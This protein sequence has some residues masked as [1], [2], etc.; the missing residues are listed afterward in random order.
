MTA[1]LN[2]ILFAKQSQ[3]QFAVACAGFLLGLFLLLFAADLYLKLTRLLNPDAAVADYFLISQDI[4]LGNTIFGGRSKL[5]DAAV[6]DLSQQSFIKDVGVFTSNQF[7]VAAYAGGNLGFSTELFFEA[8]PDRFIDNCPPSFVWREDS[9]ELPVVLSQEMLNLYNFGYALS[10]GLP[11]LS[12]SA[13]ALVP[14]QVQISGKGGVR[15]FRGK[16]VGFSERIPSVIVPENFMRWANRTIGENQPESGAARVVAR[17]SNP[18]SPEL[19]AYMKREGLVL[20]QDKLNASKAGGAVQTVMSFVGVL[21]IFLTLSSLVIFTMNFRVILAEAQE[22]VR[23]LL[24]LGYTGEMLSRQL[25]QRFSIVIA[26]LATVAFALLFVAAYLTQYFLA[27][28][29]L[30]VSGSA[31]W[32][33]LL[34]GIAFSATSVFAN[35]YSVAQMMKKYA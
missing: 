14:F 30:E 15:N 32:L 13:F 16:I 19:S 9:D 26:T 24:Q 29:G 25:F 11:Q 1:L 35:R 31:E 17:V 12:K 27:A 6:A 34:T 20:N 21:G 10:R 2:K 4:G 33:A 8:V 5:S 7:R 18:G 22:E 28:R 23:L 3:A